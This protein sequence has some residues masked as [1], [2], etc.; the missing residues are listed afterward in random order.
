MVSGMTQKNV[1]IAVCV[2]VACTLL[3]LNGVAGTVQENLKP[4]VNSGD[5]LLKFDWPSVE[6]GTAEYEEGPTGVTVFRFPHRALGAVDVRGGAPG[7]VNSD[8][9]RLGYDLPEIDAVVFA[10]GSW[11]GLE[12]VT[13]VSSA[14]KD[15][16][17]R[18]GDAFGAEP[19]IALSTGSIIFDFGPRRF[20]EI[21]PDKR[22][23]QAAF[24]AARSGAFPLG[25]HGAGRFATTGSYFG[26]NA[27]SGEGGAFRQIGKIKIAAFSVV[28]AF[29]AVTTRDG[30]LAACY[31]DPAWPKNITVSQLMGNVPF[32][33]KTGWAGPSARNTTVSL[34]VTNQKLTPVELQRLAV[35]VHTSM[36][37][38]IQP[39]STE[40]DGDVLYAV[41]TGEISGK[42]TLWP[43]DLGVVASELM[44]DAVLDSVPQQP[45]APQPNRQ[46]TLSPSQLQSYDGTYYFSPFVSVRVT[47]QGAKLFAQATGARDA[48]AIGRKQKTE[49][50]PVSTGEFTVPGRYPLVLRFDPAGTLTVNPGHW[51]QIGSRQKG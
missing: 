47:S 34:V 4:V 40:Y 42:D 14:L 25:S 27:F 31:R 5:K 15:D 6:V 17:I 37:R 30:K 39:F 19:N 33:R 29:G 46:L 20:N 48:Y 32:S 9:I 7:T 10:G 50:L 26:C 21:Y 12:A 51:A 22:L 45:V 1:R 36:G 3:S 2:A 44:W 24:H 23:A 28:N 49:L 18:N 35:Q 41:S 38:A 11:Y 43:P 13:A 8:Y 16:G